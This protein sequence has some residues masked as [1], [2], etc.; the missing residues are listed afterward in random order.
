MEGFERFI[1]DYGTCLVLATMALLTITIIYTMLPIKKY[2][3]ERLTVR[4]VCYLCRGNGEAGNDPEFDCSPCKGTGIISYE[5]R[6]GHSIFDDYSSRLDFRA[7]LNEYQIN[8]FI[9]FQTPK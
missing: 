7:N 1:D 5:I 3:P 9:G 6:V 2:Q 8:R 4:F